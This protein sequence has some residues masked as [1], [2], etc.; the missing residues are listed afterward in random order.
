MGSQLEFRFPICVL[1][2]NVT[3]FFPREEIKTET[4]LAEDCR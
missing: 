3:G 2:M 4:A 1:H